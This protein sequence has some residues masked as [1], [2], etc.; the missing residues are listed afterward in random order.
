[1]R[2]FTFALMAQTFNLFEVRESALSRIPLSKTEDILDK[3]PR[4]A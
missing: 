1:M 3:V 4:W 2:G